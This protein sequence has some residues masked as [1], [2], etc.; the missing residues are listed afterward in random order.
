[1]NS[2]NISVLSVAGKPD[3]ARKEVVTS[4]ARPIAATFAYDG[5]PVEL[6]ADHPDMVDAMKFVQYAFCRFTDNGDGTATIDAQD[7][8]AKLATLN[9]A[10]QEY[11]PAALQFTAAHRGE[12]TRVALALLEQ[13][14]LSANDV[15]AL[16]RTS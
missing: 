3:E 10:M 14:E 13:G 7:V 2:R 16:C 1:M 11:V 4:L 5:L 8:N 9:W 12:I 6:P 15:S